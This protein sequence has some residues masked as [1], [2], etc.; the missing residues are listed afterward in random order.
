ML[1]QNKYQDWVLND[2]DKKKF[3][4]NGYP[5]SNQTKSNQIS[6]PLCIKYNFSWAYLLILVL[7]LSLKWTEIFSEVSFVA[8]F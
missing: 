4:R 1:N 5:L 6:L 3:L 7:V 2:S 8:G